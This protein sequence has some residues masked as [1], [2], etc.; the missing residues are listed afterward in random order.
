MPVSITA[1]KPGRLNETDSGST[2][3]H[4]LYFRDFSFA[5]CHRTF[6]KQCSGAGI[7]RNMVCNRLYGISSQ[8]C[9]VRVASG[10][11]W[12]NS[13]EGAFPSNPTLI[14]KANFGFVAKY[15][16]GATIPTGETE[17]QFHAANLDFHSVSYEWLV[18]AGARAQYKG[19]GIIKGMNGVFG[20]MLTA[21][22]GQVNGGGGIDKFRIK[23]GGA[24]GIIVYDNQL[25]LSDDGDPTTI[26][27]GGSIVLH[28]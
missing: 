25:G 19:A 26:L 21:I 10:G 16:K 28:K 17:F 13:P 23:I 18:V 15:Q 20:F 8:W 11:G 22:D 1:V 7:E 12:I 4:Q 5:F 27:G 9:L 2:P 24:G 6:S 3:T 14:G